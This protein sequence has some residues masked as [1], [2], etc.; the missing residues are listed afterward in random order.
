MPLYNPPVSLNPTLTALAAYDTNGLLT[1]TATSTFTGRT[2]TGTTNQV[3]VTN[4]NGVSGNPT[5]SLPQ[6][7]ATTSTPTFGGMTVSGALGVT[8]GITTVGLVINT[9]M[10]FTSNANFTMNASLIFTNN[11]NIVAGTGNGTK[12]GTGTTQKLGFWNAT[13]VVQN[14][15]WSVTNVTPDKTYDANST[16]L[17]ELADV[18]GTLIDT[19]K[20]YGLLG[21]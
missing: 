2:I 9:G 18:L 20:T 11:Q 17:D 13:P 19:L 1:Q 4:G 3:T 21:A 15:G 14:T 10:A 5:L 6:D 12:I 8:S 7:I 16:T